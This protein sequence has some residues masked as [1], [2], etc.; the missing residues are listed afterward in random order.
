M[1]E[2]YPL[3]TTI[4]A[5]VVLAFL[6]GLIAN[7]L[8]L[9]TILGY[10]L[11]G[12]LIGPNTPGFIADINIAEQLAEIGVIL[13]MFG[14][15]LHFSTNDLIKVHRIAIPGAIIQML[16]TTLICLIVAILMKHSFL[17]SLVFGITLSVASTVVLLRTLEDYKIIDSHVGKIAIGWLIYFYP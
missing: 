6:L 15:G 4:V 17:E 7:Q 11:A 8:K 13:L 1:L 2:S 9:P 16:I 12:M 5:S 3:I 14:V 10:L